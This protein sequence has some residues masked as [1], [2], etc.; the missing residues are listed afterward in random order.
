MANALLM[1]FKFITGILGH[2][3]A[4]IT[5]AVHSISDLFTD[6]IVLFGIRMG[7]RGPDQN[8]PFGHARLETLASAMVG[9][10][11]V[12]TACYLGL[13]AAFNIYHHTEYTP[14]KLALMGAGVSIAVKEA[15]YHYTVRVGR[16]I[17]SRLIVANAWHHRS[18]SLSSVAVFLGVTGSL[19][20]PAWHTLDAFAALLV[21]FF[22]V[23]V[24][25]DILRDS[26]REF[27]DTAP[28]L[29]ILQDIK[30]CAGRVEGVLNTH[31]VR[32][33]TSGGRYLM[34]IHIVVDG[35]QPVLEGHRIAKAV[36]RCLIDEVA[37][38]ERVIVHVD[39][40]NN[41]ENRTPKE[42]GQGKGEDPFP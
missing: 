36:E 7:R 4:L 10:A 33:R 24:G 31:D 5:D 41:E 42:G 40:E 37:G 35:E 9:I 17:H 34:E 29:E 14:T 19:I 12:L 13:T 30:D 3:Q 32:V 23:K 20:N 6:I 18:D 26:I 21:S 28:P 27:T 1:A 8:H 38:V 2:S 11:L 39:P 15:L 25:L 16:R 22:V